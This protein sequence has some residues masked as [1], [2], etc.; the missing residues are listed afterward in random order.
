[1]FSQNQQESGLDVCLTCK[2]E[3][4]PPM[5]MSNMPREHWCQ[6][7]KVQRP[8]TFKYPE[9]QPYISTQQRKNEND[10]AWRKACKEIIDR[11]VAP[12]MYANAMAMLDR[13][14]LESKKGTP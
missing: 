2:R 9:M 11:C 6:C 1:M 5:S 14:Y 12:D 3:I 13:A 10:E 4:L 8:A 7:V